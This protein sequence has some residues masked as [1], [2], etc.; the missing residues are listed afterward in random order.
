M[1]QLLNACALD[2]YLLQVLE[3]EF[4]PLREFHFPQFHH[5]LTCDSA[6]AIFISARQRDLLFFIIGH[7]YQF[8]TG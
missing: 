2:L 4:F 8:I 1:I 5:S 3:D 7:R 6:V